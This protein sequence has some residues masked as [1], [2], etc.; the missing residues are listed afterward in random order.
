MLKD[1]ELKICCDFIDRMGT[2]SEKLT[3]TRHA[4]TSMDSAIDL[5]R[6]KIGEVDVAQAVKEYDEQE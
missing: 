6:V 5:L 3:N 1:C 2:M 4:V